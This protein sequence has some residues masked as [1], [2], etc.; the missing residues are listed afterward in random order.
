MIKT[1]ALFCAAYATHTWANIKKNRA[2]EMTRGADRHLE[3][4][5]VLTPLQDND[6]TYLD[7]YLTNH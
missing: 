3:E 1:F 2:Q 4:N 7:L 6:L 5:A